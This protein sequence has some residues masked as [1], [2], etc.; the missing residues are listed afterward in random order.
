MVLQKNTE[1]LARLIKLLM[2]KYMGEH[3]QKQKFETK[4]KKKNKINSKVF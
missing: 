3:E 2:K 4:F 1:N